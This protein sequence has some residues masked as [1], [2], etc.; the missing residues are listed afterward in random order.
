MG[1][2]Y[3]KK[4]KHHG[5][6]DMNSCWATSISWWTK[7]MSLNFKRKSVEVGEMI[8]KFMHLCDSNGGMS[9]SSIRKVCEDAEIRISLNYLS[10]D[11]FKSYEGL[12][13]PMIVIFNYPIIGGTH[14]NVIFDQKGSTVQCMEPYHPFPGTDGTRTGKFIRRNLSFFCNSQQIGVGYLPLSDVA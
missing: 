4:L 10:P 7:A 8:G 12:D 11:R 3:T 5:Q 9:I 6:P 14:M 13:S 2:D 1:Y